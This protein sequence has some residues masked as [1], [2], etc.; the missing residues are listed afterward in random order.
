MRCRRLRVL[1]FAFLKATCRGS[2]VAKDRSSEGTRGSPIA[3]RS[4]RRLDF[5]ALYLQ[6]TLYIE[7][8]VFSDCK[9]VPICVNLN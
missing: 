5:R 9:A 7:F 4:V 8:V 1:L 2:P 6:Y 3:H